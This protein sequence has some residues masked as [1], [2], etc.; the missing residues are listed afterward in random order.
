MLGYWSYRLADQI[1]GT[2]KQVGDALRP[3]PVLP[4]HDA[5]GY[6]RADPPAPVS[7][8]AVETGA[9]KSLPQTTQIKHRRRIIRLRRV[10]ASER[11]RLSA[12]L[13]QR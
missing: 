9:F 10:E 12:A 7:I 5:R 4:R 8:S 1:G 11:F 6:S 13:G 3:K 2:L